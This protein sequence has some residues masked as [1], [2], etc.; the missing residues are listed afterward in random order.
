[1]IPVNPYAE[2]ILGRMALDRL[3]EVDP[4]IDLV[5]VFRP[6]EE[7]GAII[8]E[9]AGR[10]D[11]PAVWLQEGIRADEAAKCARAAGV[12]VVQDLCLFKAHR[13]LQESL[14]LPT[15]RNRQGV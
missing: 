10:P 15:Y 11:R 14:P 13:A 9:V 3:A 7:A 2:R 12:I 5:L 4:P 8:E 6:S 1:V